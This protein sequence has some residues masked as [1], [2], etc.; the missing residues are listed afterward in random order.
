MNRLFKLDSMRDVGNLLQMKNLV[1][2]KQVNADV[3]KSYYASENFF[4]KVTEAMLRF[5]LEHMKDSVG[6]DAISGSGKNW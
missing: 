4:N 6:Q 3:R 2:A 1:N 5:G